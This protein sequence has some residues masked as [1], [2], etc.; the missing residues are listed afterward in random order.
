M[1]RTPLPG[2]A[3]ITAGRKQTSPRISG[4]ESARDSIDQAI[5]RSGGSTG[6]PGPPGPFG[7]AT[8]PPASS[9][10]DVCTDAMRPPEI[11]EP[12]NTLTNQP[13]WGGPMTTL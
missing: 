8:A 13:T 6:P 4:T 12:L 3:A 11:S 2:C 10:A 1:S 9:R 7:P 5:G